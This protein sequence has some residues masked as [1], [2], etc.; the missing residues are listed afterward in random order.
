MCEYISKKVKISFL[1]PK[2]ND[3]QSFMFPKLVCFVGLLC[4]DENV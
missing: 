3:I 2:G 1:V 4:I